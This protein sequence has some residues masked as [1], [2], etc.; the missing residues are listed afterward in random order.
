MILGSC[1]RYYPSFGV[2]WWVYWQMMNTEE[3]ACVIGIVDDDRRVVE[4]VWNLLESAGYDVRLFDSGEGFLQAGA[5][6]DIDL[7]ICD[8]RMPGMDGTELL[9][10]LARERPRLPVILITACSDLDLTRIQGSNNR[11]VFRKPIDGTALIEAISAAIA[12][13]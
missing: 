4:S 6:N 7:L 3:R 1:R 10:R 2:S 12:S 13:V 9:R 5:I 11:G 8:I